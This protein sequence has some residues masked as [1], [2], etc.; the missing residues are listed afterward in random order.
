MKQKFA[1]N[2]NAPVFTKVYF[3][4]TFS[5]KYSIKLKNNN[6]RIIKSHCSQFEHF[7][8]SI[9]TP[10]AT[11]MSP[12][13]LACQQRVLKTIPNV[14]RF[15]NKEVRNRDMSVKFIYNSNIQS[16]SRNKR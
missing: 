9:R 10:V 7:R 15:G 1:Y 3:S 2:S 16:W 11:L 5:G 14:P 4:W 6:N 13:R 12:S 8:D